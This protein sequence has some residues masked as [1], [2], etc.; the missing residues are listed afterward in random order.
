MFPSFS[1]SLSIYLSPYLPLPYSP[2]YLHLSLSL[3]VLSVP[4]LF[5]LFCLSF[6]VLVLSL[7]SLSL[8]LSLSVS[9]SL[10]SHPS[11]SVSASLHQAPRSPVQPNLTMS[12]RG[13]FC[14]WG[15]EFR[16]RI[17]SQKRGPQGGEPGPSL[18]S[19][20]CPGQ[21]C[22]PWDHKTVYEWSPTH[23]SPARFPREA[24]M[25]PGSPQEDVRTRR[26]WEAMTGTKG[27]CGQAMWAGHGSV[28]SI[29]LQLAQGSL[30][31]AQP[32]VFGVFLL[33]ASVPCIH[34]IAG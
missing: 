12:L 20:A 25:L 28:S 9:L 5:C 7:P 33:L 17:S 27:S 8:S 30:T 16:M 24:I 18:P 19:P 32:T 6:P 34:Q 10:P 13:S 1:P 31:L 14:T 11:H 29:F 3:S 2:S 23:W 26:Q 21:L 22:L 15:S 4:V